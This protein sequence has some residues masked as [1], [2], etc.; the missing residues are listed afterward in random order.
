MKKGNSVSFTYLK[1][2]EREFTNVGV[3]VAKDYA[4]NAEGYSWRSC[5]I[6]ET[7]GKQSPLSWETLLRYGNIEGRAF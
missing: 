3:V 7:S 6:F 4:K 5:Q 1:D 2:V